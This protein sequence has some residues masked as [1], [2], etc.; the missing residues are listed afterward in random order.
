MDP[1]ERVDKASAAHKRAERGLYETRDELHAA[2]IDA[3]SK[4]V[5]QAELA[6][7]TGYS[8]ERL[9]QIASSRS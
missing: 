1:I 4:G 6:R 5:S 8:R 2:I 9:R 3:L 7:R